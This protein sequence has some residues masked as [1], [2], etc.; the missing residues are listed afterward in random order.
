MSTKENQGVLKR[1]T[2]LKRG[3]D[4]SVWV[5]EHQDLVLRVGGSE[6]S[7]E[8]EKEYTDVDTLLKEL[9]KQCKE[10][11][12]DGFKKIGDQT[13]I[14]VENPTVDELE[15]QILLR[16]AVMGVTDT[17]LLKNARV[18][19]MK[20][21]K[22]EN[23]EHEKF[24]L[25]VMEF[26]V[27]LDDHDSLKELLEWQIANFDEFIENMQ[28]QYS[29][30]Y[31]KIKDGEFV[32]YESE[33][34]E[35]YNSESF[36]YKAAAQ[37][38]DLRPLI[39]EFVEMCGDCDDTMYRDEETPA[40]A[41]AAFELALADKDH[42]RNYIDFCNAIDIRYYYDRFNV[43]H[44]KHVPQLILKHGFDKNDELL[45]EFIA[46]QT[47]QRDD[48]HFAEGIYDL[49]NC[50]LKSHIKDPEFAEKLFRSMVERAMFIYEEKLGNSHIDWP[51]RDLATALEIIFEIETDKNTLVP[52]MEKMEDGEDCP[53][54]EQFK[55]MI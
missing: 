55:Q 14:D 34:C 48:Q 21:L 36:F 16:Y 51:A 43:H 7:E 13:F 27:D 39:A 19:A 4:V 5:A 47:V 42:L 12:S 26:V 53:T 2:Y 29:V 1:V 50:G 20:M 18:E 54:L 30:S 52:V 15:S 40:G 35:S 28:D 41:W 32:V 6:I 25:N 45:M 33:E 8:I 3:D 11:E 37:H 22:N 31:G 10:K 38:E 23:K 17:V 24:D 9:E 46:S 44:A 49:M